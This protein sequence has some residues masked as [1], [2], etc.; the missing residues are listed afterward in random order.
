MR[1]SIVLDGVLDLKWSKY[2]T[3]KNH[4]V[5]TRDS[6]DNTRSVFGFKCTKYS[7][8]FHQSRKLRIGSLVLPKQ[9]TNCRLMVG[10]FHKNRKRPIQGLQIWLSKRITHLF[11]HYQ[12]FSATMF[13]FISFSLT[14]A[15]SG[16]GACRLDHPESFLLSTTV[17][18]LEGYHGLCKWQLLY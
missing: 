7:I 6:A 8:Y 9:Q 3:S 1:G 10:A 15:C 18:R 14:H 12:P 13:G 5:L 17:Q 11:H 4:K 16:A 2:D